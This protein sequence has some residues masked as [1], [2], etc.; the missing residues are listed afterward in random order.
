MTTIVAYEWH[1][2]VDVVESW[3]FPAFLDAV[4]WVAEMRY[5][6]AKREEADAEE[7]QVQRSLAQ[8]R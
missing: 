3:S 1:T 4:R 7:S 6:K 2:T 5:G 8:M